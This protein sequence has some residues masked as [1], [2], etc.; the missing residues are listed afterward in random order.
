ME[1]K[2]IFRVFVLLIGILIALAAIF[3]LI[4]MAVAGFK[5]ETEVLARPFKFF[6]EKVVFEN[7]ISLLRNRIDTEM[8]G[9]IPLFPEGVSFVRSMV[10]TF[11]VS[12]FSVT[13]SLLFNSMAA[14]VFARLEF[15]FKKLLWIYYLIP[16]FVPAISVYVSQYI[17][18][19]KIGILD[20]F[21]VLTLPAIAN[22]FCIF[23]Y[24]QFYLN[25]PTSL[26]E[27]A[28]VDGAT[29]FKT[30]LHVFLPLSRTPFIV[31]GMLVFLGYWSWFLWPAMTISN[32]KIF[33][34]NQLVS[35]FRSAYRVQYQMTMAAATIAAIPSI[36]LFLVFQKHITQGL[37]ITG[38]R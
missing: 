11:G 23:F 34:I 25:I 33:M 7:Y 1:R 24:R 22:V 6:P 32:P 4:W 36:V 20:T 18:S 16:W 10:F 30:Y 13:L 26:E 3:P 14:Y 37:K 2:R 29:R 12:I 38:M 15:P 9:G 28:L 35:T 19:L 21:A 5:T 17:V 8:Y 31:M 27:S